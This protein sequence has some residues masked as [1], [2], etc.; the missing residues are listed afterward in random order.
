MQIIFG[1]RFLRAAAPL[2]GATL[3]RALLQ[4]PAHTDP[5]R[6]Q[7]ESEQERVA[8]IRQRSLSVSSRCSTR[9]PIARPP[10]WHW[11]R[12]GPSHCA[13]RCCS[14]EFVSVGRD[15]LAERSGGPS[16]D[17][18]HGRGDAVLR[19]VADVLIEAGQRTCAFEVVTSDGTHRRVDHVRPR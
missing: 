4:E 18:L 12:P 3:R 13:V 7:G 8:Q 1:R 16:G 2:A 17:V 11:N 6:V 14:R 9:T 15:E 19:A 10:S 5:T